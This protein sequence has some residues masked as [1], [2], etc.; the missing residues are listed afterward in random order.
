MIYK[1]RENFKIDKMI[2]ADLLEEKKLENIKNM[3]DEKY[4]LNVFNIAF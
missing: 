4:R 2:F 1:N 3:L